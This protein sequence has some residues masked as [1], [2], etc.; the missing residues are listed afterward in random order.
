MGLLI[1]AKTQKKRAGIIAGSVAI[2][3]LLAALLWHFTS[4]KPDAPTSTANVAT[5]SSE[6]RAPVPQSNGGS[7]S[8]AG[9]KT[10]KEHAGLVR[11][12]QFASTAPLL[13]TMDSKGIV[14]TWDTST[15]ALVNTFQGRTPDEQIYCAALTADGDRVFAAMRGADE[16]HYDEFTDIVSW[17]IRS[18]QLKG[19]FKS[20]KKGVWS[21]AV[22]PDGRR[23][24]LSDVDMVALLD[25][26]SG[27]VLWSD[28]HIKEVTRIAF[29]SDSNWLATGT[30]D[31]TVK[32]LDA[33]TGRHAHSFHTNGTGV[34]NSLGFSP[35]L[36]YVYGTDS[37]CFVWSLKDGTHWEREAEFM[38]SYGCASLSPNGQILATAIA[39]NTRE[40]SKRHNAVEVWDTKGNKLATKSKDNAPLVIAFSPDSRWLAIGYMNGTVEVVSIDDYIEPVQNFTP[41][42]GQRQEAA[43]SQRSANGNSGSQS[44]NTAQQPRTH[45]GGLH[46]SVDELEIMTRCKFR[47]APAN[48]GVGAKMCIHGTNRLILITNGPDENITSLKMCVIVGYDDAEIADSRLALKLFDGIVRMTSGP[49]ASKWINGKLKAAIGKARDYEPPTRIFDGITVDTHSKVG[50]GVGYSAS[51]GK[52]SE[53]TSELAFDVT[54]SVP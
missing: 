39:A 47:P 12:V 29:S 30:L 33:N 35:A 26:S 49:E 31:R 11:S 50:M 15:W 52:I 53:K 42:G 3:G 46:F 9:P 20:P 4:K 22:S 2:A 54:I 1:P 7:F 25:A 36:D 51:D 38:H 19:A 40:Q 16:K 28:S 17:N 21:L 32:V 44:N 34:V 43:P 48:Q 37:D 10:F 18:G 6:N 13:L 5:P 8:I 27:D 23:L 14:K 24:A 45:S 41:S